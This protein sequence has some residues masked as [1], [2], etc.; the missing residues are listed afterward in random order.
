MIEKGGDSW[1][2]QVQGVVRVRDWSLNVLKVK[3]KGRMV[4]TSEGEGKS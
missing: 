2:S 4:I 1:G 3:R